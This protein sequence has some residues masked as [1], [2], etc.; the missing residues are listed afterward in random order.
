[1][2]RKWLAAIGIYVAALLVCI[3]AIYLI[4][5]LRGILDKTYV[6]EIGSLDI[7]D[8]VSA[9]IVRDE[10]VYV[11]GKDCKVNRLA[12]ANRLVKAGTRVAE[13][14]PTGDDS[15]GGAEDQEDISARFV[16]IMRELGDSVVS[17]SSGHCKDAG[18]VSYY[19]D[20]A[21]AAFSTDKLIDLKMDDYEKLKGYRA[22]E[23]SAHKCSKGEPVFKIVRNSKWYL[24]FYLDNDAAAKYHVGSYVYLNVGE[25]QVRV[26]VSDVANGD[27]TSRVTL[28]C[29]S[30]FDGFLEK[31]TLN[32]VV[33]VA[34]AEGLMLDDSS[35][36]L[37]SDG[38]KGVF[39]K[40][41]LGEHVFR[42]ISVK[43]DDGKRCVVYSDIYVDAEGNF[44]ETLKT[45]DE[46]VAQPNEEDLKSK[47]A[48]MLMETLE[49]EDED[50]SA[51][52]AE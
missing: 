21:E 2:N 34:S 52:K 25:D 20:G 31:R 12:E 24:V 36:V 3:V 33:T 14:T 48:A 9:Y 5:S 4:P 23:T 43:A 50:G 49:E 38:Q 22:V 32:T 27:G 51:L 1:M 28:K 30:F 26:Q 37:T 6:A 19:V 39:V 41:K 47:D 17:T 13:L 7:T 46:I 29:K 18:Y 35:I 11:A 10:T 42:P 40:N 8:K 44:V 16:S 45:Y 15:A